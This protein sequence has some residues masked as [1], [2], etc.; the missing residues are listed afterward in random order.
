M[1]DMGCSSVGCGRPPHLPLS[2]AEPP[3]LARTHSGSRSPRSGSSRG[4]SVS[5]ARPWPH[6]GWS[7]GTGHRGRQINGRYEDPEISVHD[8]EIAPGSH[9]WIVSKHTSFGFKTG[10]LSRCLWV[11][12]AVP[13]GKSLPANAGDVRDAG[14]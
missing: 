4:C 11:S 13:A 5:T 3:A 2:R 10:L 1:T 7:A 14:V 8:C 6:S 9:R 12:Q